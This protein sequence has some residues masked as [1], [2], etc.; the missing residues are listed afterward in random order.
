MGSQVAICDWQGME[1]GGCEG[2]NH[3]GG[4]GQ[5]GCG[6]G[7]HILRDEE[8]STHGGVVRRKVT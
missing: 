1:Q 6:S 7:A 2:G 8:N 3:D 4:G 5:G